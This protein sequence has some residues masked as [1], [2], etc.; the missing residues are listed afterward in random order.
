MILYKN[1]FQF[2]QNLYLSLYHLLLQLGYFLEQ[3][4]SIQIC[5][6]GKNC[7]YFWM[8]AIRG[9]F[10]KLCKKKSDS[11]H[12]KPLKIDWWAKIYCQMIWK[13][14]ARNFHR[15]VQYKS[16]AVL[17]RWSGCYSS[18]V[19]CGGKNGL[20]IDCSSKILITF[21]L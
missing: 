7:D 15:F 3:T 11:R 21:L 16:I 20:L 2:L 13:K 4:L 12:V 9:V 5:H 6:T 1:H 10:H 14:Q 8:S 18:V 17:I 19:G